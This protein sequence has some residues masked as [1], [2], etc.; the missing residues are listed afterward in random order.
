MH[1]IRRLVEKYGKYV[2][3]AVV[4]SFVVGAFVIFTPGGF[5]PGTRTTPAEETVLIVN[6]EKVSKAQYERAYLEILNEQRQFNQDMGRA[7]DGP[8]GAYRQ[9][10][11]RVQAVDRLIEKTLKEI[12]AKKRLISVPAKKIDE[13]Y[14]QEYDNFLVMLRQRYGIDEKEL[15]RLLKEQYNTSLTAYQRQMREQVTATLKEEAL[16]EA[17]V[18][19]IEVTD[20]QLLEFIEQNKTRYVNDILGY[21]QPATAELQAYF[22]ANREKYATPEVKA[23]HILVSVEQDASEDKVTEA[24]KKIEEIRKQLDKGADFAELAKN[25]DDK[26]NAENGGDLGWFGKGVMVKEFEEAAFALDIGKVS[27]PVR[28]QFGFHL[29]KVE[30]K[31]VRNFEQAQADVRRD[32]VREREDAL[33]TQWLE[34][35]KQGQAPERVRL[36]RIF[37]PVAPDAPEDE[38]IAARKRL[39][40]AK[41][42]LNVEGASFSAVA[43]EYSKDPDVAERGGDLGYLT[44]SELPQELQSAVAKLQAGQVSDLIQTPEGLFLMRLEDRKNLATIREGL[45][46]DYRVRQRVDSFNEWLKQTKASATIELKLPLIAAYQLEQQEKVDEAI[47]AYE[48]LLKESSTEGDLPVVLLS[49]NQFI[50]SER[51]LSE[52]LDYYVARLYQ[53]KIRQAE[54]EKANLEKQENV[55]NKEAKLQELEQKIKEY[56]QKAVQHLLET[57]KSAGGDRGFYDQLIALDPENAQ[58]HYQYGL[59]L[60]TEGDQ[61]S[62]MDAVKQTKRAVDLAPND[63]GPL[64]LYGHLMMSLKNYTAAIEHYEKALAVLSDPVKDKDAIRTVKQKLAEAHFGL[65]NWDKSEALYTELREQEIKE[66]GFDD[67]RLVTAL[68]DIASKKNDY[69]RAVTLYLESL[70]LQN[71]PNVRLKLGRAYEGLNDLEEATKHYAQVIK[72]SPYLAEAYLA[73]G[74]LQRKQEKLEEALKNYREGFKRTAAVELREQLGERIIEL[75]PRD[76]ETR[77]QLARQYQKQH[78]YESAVRH[79]SAILEQGPEPQQALAAYIGL[80][81]VATGRAEHEQAKNHYKSGLAVATTDDQKKNLYEKIL[82]A[83]RSLVGTGAKLGE[84]GLDALYQLAVIARNQQKMADMREQLEKLKAEDQSYRASEV[85]QMLYEVTGKGPDDKPGMPVALQEVAGPVSP[86]QEHEPYSSVPPT[87]GAYIDQEVVFGVHKEQIAEELQV[88]ALRGSAVLIQYG[89]E[90]DAA[91]IT[92]L[93]NLLKR[94]QSEHAEKYCRLVLTPYDKLEPKQISLT[95]WGRIDKLSSYDESRVK[96]FID[97]WIGNGPEQLPCTVGEQSGEE[98]K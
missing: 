19:Q 53:V 4:I 10:Q 80:G 91:T 40:E 1:T 73:F 75:D 70:K 48:R 89:P 11:W 49:N 74:D 51:K 27:A 62:L 63:P 15:A 83:E 33:M 46:N 96:G 23:R 3:W 64:R 71:N 60:F 87:S 52:Y 90:T 32:W 47:A 78:I 50:E 93:E 76:A 58:A 41:D 54:Q 34:A 65:E 16:E 21:M 31:R 26:S 86:G 81:E 20:A 85:A 17:V 68:A 25:S 7:L 94:L 77:F 82:E 84:D 18:G 9:L 12:E 79:Y 88:R 30:D 8:E 97:E 2:I 61:Q 24:Q 22:E 56:A 14:K 13:R 45:A 43:R 39:Q 28:T 98:H 36:S 59:F 6:G 55:E 5:N 69:E 35:A 92:Q 67:A 57:A 42:K 95:A 38:L 66:R 37:I 72:E 44:L 29:I